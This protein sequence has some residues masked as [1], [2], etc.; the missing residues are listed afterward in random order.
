MTTDLDHFT[1]SFPQGYD[2]RLEFETPSKGYLRD[3][4]VQLGDGS[5]YKLFFIDPIRLEQDLQADVAN[6]R[7]YYSEPGMV[8]LHEVTTESIRK[9]VSGLLRD[10]F[11]RRMKPL[12]DTNQ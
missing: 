9:A 12:L 3:V 10:G 5:K 2:D 8:V 1:I 4:V 7:E 6:G 11:F